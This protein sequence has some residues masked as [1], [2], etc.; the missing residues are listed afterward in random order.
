MMRLPGSAYC[1][2]LGALAGACAC[3]YPQSAAA[4]DNQVSQI[5]IMQ[6]NVES[7]MQPSAAVGLF[8]S[9]SSTIQ[10]P[11]S[12]IIRTA[13]NKLIVSIPFR[14]GEIPRDAMATALVT[15]DQGEI[16]LGDVRPVTAPESRE[17]F[18]NLP[19]C[20]PEKITELRMEG[21]QSLIESLI[22]VRSERRKVAQQAVEKALSGDFLVRMQKLEE[23]FGL[24]H[25]QPLGPELPPVILI[26]RLTRIMEA[27][28]TYEL[29]V[30]S[31]QQPAA[32]PEQAS[33]DDQPAQDDSN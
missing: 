16:A 15:S 4:D 13:D 24:H 26:D 7:A 5:R 11:V 18:L 33:E 28:K 6:I 31:K 9:G 10:L 12:E 17:S 30:K 8:I 14:E 22:K 21:Q 1:L 29:A 23:S 2:L 3:I 27:I 32:E 25:E 20:A 19:E